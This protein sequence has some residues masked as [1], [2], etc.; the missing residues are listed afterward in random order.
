[1][2]DDHKDKRE[3]STTETVE[4]LRSLLDEIAIM[5]R[6]FKR[7]IEKTREKEDAFAVSRE[8]QQSA[9]DSVTTCKLI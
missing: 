7:L 6:S 2:I 9:Q 4:V 3:D 1:M 8:P 5:E